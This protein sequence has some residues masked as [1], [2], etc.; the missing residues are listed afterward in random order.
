MDCE[1][2]L[3]GPNAS[4]PLSSRLTTSAA[5][6][7]ARSTRPFS[8]TSNGKHGLWHNQNTKTH[9]WIPQTGLGYEHPCHLDQRRVWVRERSTGVAEHRVVHSAGARNSCLYTL[10]LGEL[11][12]RRINIR[13]SYSRPYSLA[14]PLA[15]PGVRVE[16]FGSGR[17]WFAIREPPS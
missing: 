1:T 14:L 2:A 16:V 13:A 10:V 12:G 6:P 4:T 8:L 11:P 7:R 9:P 5:R 15:R 3:R 17:S